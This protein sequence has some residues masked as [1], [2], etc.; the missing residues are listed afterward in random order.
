MTQTYTLT[1]YYD[2]L[3]VAIA[4]GIQFTVLKQPFGVTPE[5]RSRSIGALIMAF[6]VKTAP[7][8]AVLLVNIAGSDALD[9]LIEVKKQLPD[10]FWMELRS[11]HG[12]DWRFASHDGVLPRDISEATLEQFY[13]DEVS[14]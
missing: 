7:V 4:D 14:R 8:D 1:L 3:R 12:Q 2:G 9:D 5:A 6:L 13:V 11:S 10:R